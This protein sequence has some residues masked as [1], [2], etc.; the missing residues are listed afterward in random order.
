MKYLVVLAERAYPIDRRRFA[1]ESALCDHLKE[2]AAV[3]SPLF[4]ELCVA[5][6]AMSAREYEATCAELGVLDLEHHHVRLHPL[7]DADLRPRGLGSL[8]RRLHRLVREH[9]LVCATPSDDLARPIG[10]AALAIGA[11]LG[12]KTLAVTGADPRKD[13]GMRVRL[14]HGARAR[15]LAGRAI[16]DPLR[17]LQ[18]ELVV[19]TASL[20]LLKGEALY[21]D[22][23]GGRPNVRAIEDPGFSAHHVLSERALERKIDALGQRGGPLELLSFGR[24]APE[25]G[26]DR[27]IAALSRAR[28]LGRDDVRL[29]I[30]GRGEDEPRLR[31]MVADLALEE[32]VVFRRPLRYGEPFFASLRPHHLAL[33]APL[34]NDAPRGAWDAIA[35]AVPLLAFDVDVYRALE[36]DHGVA[37]TV[38]WPSTDALGARIAHYARHREELAPKMR[39]CVALARENTAERWL[40]RRAAWTL[41]LFGHDA[42]E[43]APPDPLTFVAA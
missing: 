29:T 20:A 16:G 6:P 17:Y 41:A 33:A 27:C 34:V 21:A 35:S 37:E 2:L 43:L 9:D 25:K 28:S 15:S 13:A 8:V 19:R 36:R 31:R 4:D 10:T 42:A 30:M 22:Y 3:S 5:A 7:D 38:P 26:V 18:Q 40:R 24:L 23:G 11:V 39:A 1:I 12:K 14:G 32:R